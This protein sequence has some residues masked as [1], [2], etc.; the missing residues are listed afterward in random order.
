MSP[1]SLCTSLATASLIKDKTET[2]WIRSLG[3][4]LYCRHSLCAIHRAA[5]RSPNA[6]HVLEE[7]KEEDS[8]H[9]SCKEEA[10]SYWHLCWHG[11]LASQE[12]NT[13]SMFKNY[14]EVRK[15]SNTTLANISNTEGQHSL[16]LMWAIRHTPREKG[17]KFESKAVVSTTPRACEGAPTPAKATSLILGITEHAWGQEEGNRKDAYAPWC[18]NLDPRE[19]PAETRVKPI[20][21]SGRYLS[22]SN[23]PH[24]LSKSLPSQSHTCKCIGLFCFD[25]FIG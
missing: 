7:E 14:T 5:R 8:A 13:A 9:V 10:E 11:A 22:A 4:C 17:W 1:K 12:A 2:N 15:T 20:F 6:P 19:N 3:R 18:T 16:F 24:Y 25:F 21:G 23:S